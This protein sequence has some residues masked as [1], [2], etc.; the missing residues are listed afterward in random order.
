MI[1]YSIYMKSEQYYEE[2]EQKLKALKPGERIQTI[3]KSKFLAKKGF[4]R[5]DYPNINK[6]KLVDVNNK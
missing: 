2:L 4:I 5:I 6:Y 1:Y 3:T